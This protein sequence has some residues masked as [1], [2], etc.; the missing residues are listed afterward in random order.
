MKQ[1]LFFIFL[2]AT[3]FSKCWSQAL[4]DTL[5]ARLNNCKTDTCSLRVNNLLVNELLLID[6]DLAN[7]TIDRINN[8]VNEKDL[9]NY[10]E[11][12]YNL[13]YV[14]LNSNNV[15]EALKVFLSLLKKSKALNEPYF[16]AKA[17]LGIS[18]CYIKKNDLKFAI[19]IAFEALRLFETYK[20]YNYISQ[21]YGQ[22]ALINSKLKNTEKA[23]DYFKKSLEVA[24]KS[25]NNNNIAYAYNNLGNI[26]SVDR[27]THDIAIEYYKRALNIR[28]QQKHNLEIAPILSNMGTV[29]FERKEYVLAEKYF[30]ES[31]ELNLKNK[32]FKNSCICYTNIGSLYF[33]QNDFKQADFNYRQALRYLGD[34]FQIKEMLYYNLGEVNLKLGNL[35][36][37]L[38][39][40][41]TCMT[42][43]DSLYSREAI[44]SL[45]DMQV[46]YETEK[47]QLELDKKELEAKN[48]TIKIYAALG[49]IVLLLGLVFFVFRGLQQK[50]KDN[51]VLEEKNIII[52]EKSKIVEEQHRDITDSIKYAERIQSAI[53][54]PDKLWQQILPNSFVYYRPKDILSG[55]FY[56]IEETETH[57]YIAAADC[58]GHGVPGALVSIINYNLLNKAVLEKHLSNP[59]DILN[60]V[61]EWLTQ[62]LH[63]S[64]NEASMRDGMDV[65]ICS[66]NKKTKLMQFAG[67]FN[68]GYLIKDGAIIEMPADKKPVGAFIE[69]SITA[70]TVKEYHLTGNETLYLFSDGYADQFGGPKGKKFKYKN[71]QNLLLSLHHLPFDEQKEKTQETFLNW[72]GSYEQ[73]DDVLLIGF[74]VS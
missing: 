24:I 66:I 7:K 9:K 56:W 49:G 58:T 45:N 19:N 43:K 12:K 18:H 50:S 11:T 51:K 29:Y 37:A 68:S 72:K 42:I 46:K 16:I 71:L 30:K 13:A 28:K 33:E 47:T 1:K 39:Y 62:A 59:A 6:K 22:I 48:N 70:F 63:Q 54:P 31:L 26:F 61:N 67:A 20:D 53:L 36:D 69:D 2:L 35:K 21:C 27:K 44:K 4:V 73:T 38:L 55:D 15:D 60:Q 57:V 8:S 17:K 74:K 52:S 23:I 5:Y 40:N 64:Y 25:R 14:K 32:D 41:D 34:D 3:F 65:S 10:F